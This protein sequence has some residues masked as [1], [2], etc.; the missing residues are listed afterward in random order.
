[1]IK[2]KCSGLAFMKVALMSLQQA[3]EPFRLLLFWTALNGADP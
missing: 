1:M 3:D 2:H